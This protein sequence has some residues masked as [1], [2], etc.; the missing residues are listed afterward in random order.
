MCSQDQT[1]YFP[2]LS[3]LEKEDTFFKVWN[4]FTKKREVKGSKVIRDGEIK[5]SDSN[6]TKLLF[7]FQCYLVHEQWQAVCRTAWCN[8][9]VT[10]PGDSNAPETMR[11]G[12][13]AAAFLSDLHFAEIFR[14]AVAS[15]PSSSTAQHSR[16][17]TKKKKKR[18][19]KR[20]TWLEFH[21]C[22]ALKYHSK[23]QEL[24]SLRF[25]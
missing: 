16:G 3:Y 21:I 5:K 8:P 14:A 2:S 15:G 4:I 12:G 10:G 6:K 13:T 23:C 20:C 11:E 25:L 9:N 1:C 22:L 24:I 17:W 18:N 19:G 7:S